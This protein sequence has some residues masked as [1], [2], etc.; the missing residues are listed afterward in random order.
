MGGGRRTTDD[1]DA[2]VLAA[3]TALSERIR[4]LNW[5]ALDRDEIRWRTRDGVVVD[6][7]PAGRPVGEIG[8][9][10]GADHRREI[11]VV[12]VRAAFA[13]RERALLGG[14]AVIGVAGPVGLLVLK[15]ASYLE[16]PFVRPHDLHDVARLLQD[17]EPQ[18]ERRFSDA[19]IMSAVKDEDVGAFLLGQDVAL[20]TEPSELAVVD[21]WVDFVED[22]RAQHLTIMGQEAPKIVEPPVD[23][24]A[25]ARAKTAAFRRGLRSKSADA[26]GSGDLPGR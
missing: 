24:T 11:G 5:T 21:R 7:I 25:W 16:A 26:R 19:V 23:K 8:R 17:Y 18:D 9:S 4:E 3:A 1:V 10:H 2:Y 15:A 13:S 14:D 6:V 12:G 22:V 20:R